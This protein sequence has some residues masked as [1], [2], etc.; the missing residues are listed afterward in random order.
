M[1]YQAM[2]RKIGQRIHEEMVD[3]NLNYKKLSEK[4]GVNARVISRLVDK[5]QG[6]PELK[7]LDKLAV[8][9]DLSLEELCDSTGKINHEGD[10]K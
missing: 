10:Q 3:K 7:T 6:N 2:L 5:F 9:L 4:S 8:A 1:S